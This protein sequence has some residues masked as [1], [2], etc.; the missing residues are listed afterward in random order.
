[1]ER[2]AYV[3][4]AP[5]SDDAL[6]YHVRRPQWSTITRNWVDT[7][8]A[9]RICKETFEIVTG[10]FVPRY[11]RVL[12]Y[13]QRAEKAAIIRPPKSHEK[14]QHRKLPRRPMGRSA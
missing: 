9:R 3:Y 5:D 6:I 11:P 12:V 14:R 4:C 8:C 13:D 2:V 10:L 1:M 7:A